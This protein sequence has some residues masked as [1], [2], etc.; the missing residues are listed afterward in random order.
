MN[1]LYSLPDMSSETSDSSPQPPSLPSHKY[2][3]TETNNSHKVPDLQNI[4][5][6][7]ACFKP[8]GSGVVYI[9]VIATGTGFGAW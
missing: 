2:Y 4:N 3:K 9:A 5:I 6:I 1:N 7:N 8:L